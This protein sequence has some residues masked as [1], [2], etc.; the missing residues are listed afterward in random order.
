MKCVCGHNF[1]KHSIKIMVGEKNS[2]NEGGC[3]VE[4]CKCK[5]FE[6]TKK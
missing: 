5:K 4:H 6:E 1:W 3:E 2:I